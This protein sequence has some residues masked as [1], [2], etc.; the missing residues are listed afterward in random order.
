MHG[1]PQEVRKQL[2]VL[3]GIKQGSRIQPP[4]RCL[5]SLLVLH[6]Q[7]L[8]GGH[9]LQSPACDEAFRAILSHRGMI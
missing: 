2:P 3:R 8:L 7:L 4:H 9:H 5:L 1:L 6:L